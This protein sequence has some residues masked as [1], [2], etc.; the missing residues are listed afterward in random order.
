MT[1]IQKTIFDLSPGEQVHYA[2]PVRHSDP[3]TSKDVAAKVKPRESWRTV[4]KILDALNAASS[5]EVSVYAKQHRIAISE[6]RIR[7]SLSPAEMLGAGYVAISSVEAVSEFG[8]DAQVYRLT[9]E[10][11]L[12]AREA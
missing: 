8:N 10:G 12:L 3:V 1:L 6:S 5:Y 4:A 7:G 2:A 9:T 11:K